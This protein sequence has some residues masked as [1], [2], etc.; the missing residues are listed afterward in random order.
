MQRLL[1]DIKPDLQQGQSKKTKTNCE[2]EIT[3]PLVLVLVRSMPLLTTLLVGNVQQLTML[4]MENMS[5]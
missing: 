2:N 4:L 5:S 3:Q 1:L